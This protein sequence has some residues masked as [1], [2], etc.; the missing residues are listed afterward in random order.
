ME[1]LVLIFTLPG[2]II[3]ACSL[4]FIALILLVIFGGR[5]GPLKLN[6][7]GNVN[8]ELNSLQS[9]LE[10]PAKIV[11]ANT[12]RMT[13]GSSE[14]TTKPVIQP[15]SST[16]QCKLGIS[17]I[18]KAIGERDR[19]VIEKFFQ[20]QRDAGETNFLGE[21]IDLAELRALS[22][23][24]DAEAIARLRELEKRE[25]AKAD[26]SEILYHYFLRTGDF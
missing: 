22:I 6:L 25:T 12:S 10:K 2:A 17:D 1:I 16:E 19:Q 14:T 13:N 24:E 21:K 4:G 9:S 7:P 20:E 26:A 5:I 8:I 23:M 18:F 15:E 3:I 11:D